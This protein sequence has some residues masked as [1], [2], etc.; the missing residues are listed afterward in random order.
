VA[1]SLHARIAAALVTVFAAGLFAGCAGQSIAAPA[2]PKPTQVTDYGPPPAGVPLIYVHDPNHQSW[3]IAYDWQ[4]KPRGTVKLASNPGYVQAAPDGSAFL[5]PDGAYLDRLG[6]PITGP[7]APQSTG[8]PGGLWADDGHHL[9]FVEVDPQTYAWSLSTQQPGE[10]VHPVAVIAHDPG[11]GQSGIA[12]VSCSLQNN[13]AILVR[14]TIWWPSEIWAV[15]LSNGRLLSH[16]TYAMT[17]LVTVVASA[18][19]AYVVESSSAAQAPNQAAADSTTVR[20]VSDWSVAASLNS[21]YQVL[22]FSGD[23]SLVL[24]TT[25]WEPATGAAHLGVIDW[26]TG[27]VIWRYD[28]PEAL[29]RSTT[30]LAGSGFVLALRA[31]T[32]LEPSPCGTAP[33]GACQQVDDPLNDIV[34]VHGDGSTTAVPGRYEPLW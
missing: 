15:R 8:I 9:C 19:G 12:A 20:K 1:L 7:P 32:R 27:R 25:H 23:G 3:L 5:A 14:T 28:G 2:S 11:L 16:H 4:G 24:V 29:Y 34:I 31:P 6:S 33:Y 21:S 26:Q 18:D 22:S 17:A 13:L 30:Q 10:A